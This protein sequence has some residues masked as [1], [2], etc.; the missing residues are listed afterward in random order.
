MW[1]RYMRTSRRGDMVV[2]YHELH[3][4]P[5]YFT[6]REWEAIQDSD[7]QSSGYAIELQ[8]R[9]LIIDTI[10]EDDRI[11][12]LMNE[13]VTH[14]YSQPNILYLMMAQDCTYRCGYCPVPVNAK[15]YGAAVL[16]PKDAIAGIDLWQRHIEDCHESQN[17]YVVIFYGGEPLLNKETVSVSLEY[18]NKKR[19]MGCLPTEI[20]FVLATNGQLIDEA[21]IA[22]CREYSMIVAVGLDGSSEQTDSLRID[23]DGNN[24]HNQSVATIARLVRAG[25]RTY[26][27]ASVTPLNIDHLPELAVFLRQ[28]GVEKFGFNLLKGAL[29]SKLVP[30]DQQE[31][32]YRQAAKGIIDASLIGGNDGFEQQMAKRQ[33][34]FDKADYFP[35]DCTCYGNQLVIQPDGQISNCPF[36]KAQLG[37]VSEVDQDF[38]IW[39]QPIVHEWRKRHPLYQVDSAKSVSGG[40]CAWSSSELKGDPLAVDEGSRILSEE[41][42]R[43]LIWRRYEKKQI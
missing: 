35:V 20:T 11:F 28:I 2:V 12:E 24:T 37:L 38:R 43:D 34:A 8:Q 39:N 7:P 14:K 19:K 13:F 9:G 10:A 29:L 1:S 31:K 6:S 25:I 21:V 33:Q 30:P 17:E 3:P 26:V 18:I 41:V 22:L 32:Y 42:L 15:K 36:F 5:V 4:D 40:G 16:S 23:L 27:S